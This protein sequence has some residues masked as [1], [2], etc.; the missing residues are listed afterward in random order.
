MATLELVERLR[1]HAEVSYDDA[2]EALDACGDDLLDAIIY[3]ERKG[4]ISPPKSNG[5]YTT[6]KQA[7]PQAKRGHK[8]PRKDFGQCV[9]RV[10]EGCGKILK[11]GN[12]NLFVVYQKGQESVSCP[13]TILVLLMIFCFWKIS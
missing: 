3:L 2:R 4:K 13:V 7:E 8:A 5:A 12:R 6:E 11:K 9:K 10:A 1:Q